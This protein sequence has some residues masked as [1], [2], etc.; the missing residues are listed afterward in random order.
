MSDIE[1]IKGMKVYGADLSYYSGKLQAYLLY[2]EVPHEWIEHGAKSVRMTAAATGLQQM[3]SI[4][5]TDGRWMSDT[6]P[7]I[8]WLDGVLPGPKVLPEDSFQRFISLLV[9]DYAEEWLWRPAMH[10]R[11][12][13]EGD[14]RHLGRRIATEIMGDLPMP[15]FLRVRMIRRRQFGGYVKGD[16]VSPQ[17]RDHVE[18]IYLRNLDWLETIFASRPFLLGERPT[19]ADYGFFASMFRHFGIDPTASRI[20]RDR[21]PGVYEW[22]ARMWNARQSKQ[23]GSL[24]EAGSVPDDWKP[25]LQDIGR[26]YL[27][28]LNANARSW[29]A[30]QQT[31]Q[32][33]VEDVSYSVPVHQYRVHCLGQ[34]QK[35]FH[36]LRGEDAEAVQA[37]LE[38]TGCWSGLFETDN[39]QSEFDIGGHAPFYQ[40]GTKIWNDRRQTR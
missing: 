17:T 40:P 13:Y 29:A 30:H 37:L 24:H 7:M 2:K 18:S 20:M 16:G 15:E 3:P 11:W 38:E 12:S 1:A 22:T 36:D 10:Y 33:T 26:C 32:F 5:L 28:Y 39:I 8:A 25:I 23:A 31:V 6:S 19:I 9:E 14:A 34:L 21:A 35:A 27:P 4:E